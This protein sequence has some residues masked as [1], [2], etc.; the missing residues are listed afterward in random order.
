MKIEE[1]CKITK[2]SKTKIQEKAQLNVAEFLAG[3]GKKSETKTKQKKFPKT[4]VKQKKGSAVETVHD[5][6]EMGF[7]GVPIDFLHYPSRITSVVEGIPK[8]PSLRAK[9]EHIMHT[10]TYTHTVSHPHR[11]EED[12]IH[13]A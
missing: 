11:C 13:R 6:S 3:A 5:A 9:L 12:A 10:H 8:P 7:Y 4:R 2:Y 1:P